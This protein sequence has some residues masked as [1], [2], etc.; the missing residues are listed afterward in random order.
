[1][2]F[3]VILFAFILLFL[4]LKKLAEQRNIPNFAFVKTLEWDKSQSCPLFV[5]LCFTITLAKVG[6]K[7]DK[8]P[9]RWVKYPII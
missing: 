3:A 6:K 9:K 2:S 8:I 5:L 1:M 7:T 4:L